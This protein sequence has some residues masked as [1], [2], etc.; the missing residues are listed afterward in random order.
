MRGVARY[1]IGELDQRIEIQS[2]QRT[3]DGAGGFTSNWQVDATVW[4]HVR[5]LRG[6]EREQADRTEASGGY[7]VVIRWRE[8]VTEDK[9]IRWIN[10]DRVMNIRFV[11]QASKRDLYL[12]IECEVGVAT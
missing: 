7:M 4:A 5:P 3:P 1:E 2:E 12:P 6:S 11:Q 10:D 8:G 9:R